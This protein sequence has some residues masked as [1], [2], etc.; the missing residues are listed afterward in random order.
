VHGTGTCIGPGILLSEKEK[1]KEKISSHFEI[2]MLQSWS[3][4]W[5]L[6]ISFLCGGV[7]MLGGMGGVGSVE[8]GRGSV[9]RGGGRGKGE[10]RRGVSFPFFSFFLS[11]VVRVLVGVGRG[12]AVW[13]C[14]GCVRWLK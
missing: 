7:V 6:H 2:K 8:C 12:V 3:W 9:E 13:G 4:L 5:L 11:L 1:E 14:G 10:G